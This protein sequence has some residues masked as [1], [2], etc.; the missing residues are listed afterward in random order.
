MVG[1]SCLNE[2]IWLLLSEDLV[3]GVKTK[4]EE[5]KNNKRFSWTPRFFNRP[6]RL[7]IS[8]PKKYHKKG[9]FHAIVYYAD[10]LQVIIGDT[11]MNIG[12]NIPGG[13]KQLMFTRTTIRMGVK[14]M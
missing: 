5:K 12:W 1:T 11:C 8:Q 3:D 13:V 9:L 10:R 6:R 14:D 4:N 7:S 2:E